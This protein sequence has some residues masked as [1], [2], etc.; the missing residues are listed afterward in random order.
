M[1]EA[2]MPRL[3]GLNVLHVV[4]LAA[5]AVSAGSAPSEG[6][7]NLKNAYV[8]GAFNFAQKNLTD[9]GYNAS[10]ERCNPNYI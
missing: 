6:F 2:V 9:A 4:L 3:T 8:W 1:D 5:T 7:I 10:I